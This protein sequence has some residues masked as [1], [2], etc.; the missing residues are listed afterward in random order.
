DL[1]KIPG[2]SYSILG[3]DDS[4][5]V[6]EQLARF[7]W[8]MSAEKGF[9]GDAGEDLGKFLR[10]GELGGRLTDPNTHKAAVEELQRFLD[11]SSKVMTATH[12][13]VTPSTLLGM[14]QQ[15]GF[16][17][18]GMT[19]EGFLNQAIMAQAMGGPRAGTAL[20]SLY[21]QVA[22]GK[23]TKPAALGMQDL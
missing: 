9:K 21:N 17:M 11:L 15:A 18:R 16:S 3:Q 2:A 13:M 5:K 22:T 10:A 7:Q 20:L 6:W 23:M 19:D 4:M 14:S 8:S 1:L 12:G